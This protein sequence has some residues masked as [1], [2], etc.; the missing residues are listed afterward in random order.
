MFLGINSLRTID[1]TVT[2]ISATTMARAFPTIGSSRDATVGS[3]TKPISNDVT[4]T[5]SCV[6]DR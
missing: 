4:V 5:P 2:R 6:P 1:P 3:A